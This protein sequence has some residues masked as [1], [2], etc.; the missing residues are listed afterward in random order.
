MENANVK[1]EL[2]DHVRTCDHCSVKNL[3]RTFHIQHED[4]DLYIGR[5]CIGKMLGVDTSGNP[6]KALDRL[7][8]KIKRIGPEA[9]L[10]FIEMGVD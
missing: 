4:I 9:T 3:K 1:I 10:E 8:K 5:I 6:Y 7:A 2:D